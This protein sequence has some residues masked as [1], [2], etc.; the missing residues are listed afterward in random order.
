MEGNSQ[1]QG[2]D[3]INTFA[4][5]LNSKSIEKKSRDRMKNCETHEMFVFPTVLINSFF[6]HAV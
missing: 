1:M 6:Y 5:K 2:F 3:S 4:T